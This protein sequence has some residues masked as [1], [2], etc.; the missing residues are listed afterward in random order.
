VEQRDADAG[1]DRRGD[2]VHRV[3]AQHQQLGAGGFQRAR[4]CGE[5]VASLVPPALDLEAC[6]GCE[7]DRGEQAVR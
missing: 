1:L 5:D 2:L 7:V 3:G 4:L 6:D